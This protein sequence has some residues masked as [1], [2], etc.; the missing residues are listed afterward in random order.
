M[1]RQFYRKKIQGQPDQLIDSNSNKVLTPQ[2]FGTGKGFQEL[3]AISGAQYNTREKQQSAFSNIRPIGNTLYGIPNMPEDNISSNDI[4]AGMTSPDITPPQGTADIIKETFVKNA[5]NFTDSASQMD[6]IYQAQIAES[7]KRKE[8]AQKKIDDLEKQ[9]ETDVTGRYEEI[10]QP[11]RKQMEDAG[12][13]EFQ[14]KEKY[15]KYSTLA[16]SLTTYADMAYNDLVAEQNRPGLLSVS[17][18][19]QANIKEDYYSKIALTQ[20]A[21]AGLSDDIAMGRTFIDRGINAVQ[22]DR[23]DELSY[24]NFVNDLIND[25]TA[26]A[27]NE[28]LTATQEEKDAIQNRINIIA[29][30]FERVETEK[31]K[32][33]DYLL[34]NSEIAIKAGVS[35]ADSYDEMVQ[36]VSDYVAKHPEETKTTGSAGSTGKTFTVGNQEIEETG[37]TFTDTV[38]YLKALRDQEIMTDFN[39][40]EQINAL[41]E[42]GGYEEAQRAEVESMVNKAMEGS[43]PTNNEIEI[44]NNPTSDFVVSGGSDVYT[45][46]GGQSLEERAN[47]LI[48]SYMNAG[49]SKSKAK[50]QAQFVL[51]QEGYPSGKVD[52]L[53]GNFIEKIFSFVSK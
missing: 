34:D 18:G 17:Q 4:K 19:R 42:L 36:K 13:E 23:N 33:K 12:N 9:R 7:T 53:V 35:L 51:K 43:L 52:R 21:M 48:N 16:Q 5:Q 27:K 30:E 22:A 6:K 31:D 40:K 44:D 10:S 25:K 32:V 26:D 14:L 15:Q 39:Y 1:S 37:D 41:M 2:E 24:L 29:S 46:E 11:F 38:N 8:E 28:L 20:A 45:E 49:M 3:K 47:Q 50:D